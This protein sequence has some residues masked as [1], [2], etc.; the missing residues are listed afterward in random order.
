MQILDQG[1][2]ALQ[3]LL[4][5]RPFSELPRFFIS[6][7]FH[8]R[9]KLCASLYFDMIS[10]MPRR[11]LKAWSCSIFR[12]LQ[13]AFDCTLLKNHVDFKIK[14]KLLK[15]P[16]IKIKW[17]IHVVLLW[18]SK[19]LFLKHSIKFKFK[20]RSYKVI[21]QAWTTVLY[22]ICMLACVFFFLT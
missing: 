14:P 15:M 8:I 2:R 21:R 20:S 5:C 12:F 10:H 6:Y 18:M 4:F 11:V 3:T 16:Q 13:Q 19:L 9:I 1:H 7:Y 17:I 22:E